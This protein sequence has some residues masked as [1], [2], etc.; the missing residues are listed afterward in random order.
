MIDT[1]NAIKTINGDIYY[2][3]PKDMVKHLKDTV[4][5]VDS[6]FGETIVDLLPPAPELLKI[7]ELVPFCDANDQLLGFALPNEI[8][9]LK[10]VIKDFKSILGLKNGTLSQVYNID[11]L[12]DLQNFIDSLKTDPRYK[13]KA[14]E[15]R[16]LES[17]Q[18]I[19]NQP[20]N[21]E[22]LQ[23]DKN[24][25]K[26]NWDLVKRALKLIMNIIVMASA[27]TGLSMTDVI[28]LFQ[29]S[30]KEKICLEYQINN[31]ENAEIREVYLA[32]GTLIVRQ[33][34]KDKGKVLA[35]LPN[36]ERICLANK[37]KG[38]QRWL[39]IHFKSENGEILT[40]YVAA[41]FTRKIYLTPM[42]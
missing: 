11:W 25:S 3:L 37:P 26:F 18:N 22:I 5:L 24:W 34:P 14:D 42:Y 35:E 9:N 31:V 7:K 4:R 20:E 12:N 2:G 19:L 10:K 6:S 15:I 32:R 36:G 23:T 8:E 28:K 41:R 21:L 1:M 16:T 27:I 40:G 33:Y 13:K 30:E 39:E 38:N 29:S 17:L